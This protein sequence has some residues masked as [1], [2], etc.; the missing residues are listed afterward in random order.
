[1]RISRL[2]LNELLVRKNMTSKKLSECSGL[3]R[4]TISAINQGKRCRND[5]GI[6]LATALNVDV[7]ELLEVVE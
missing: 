1:M 4:Q 2:K 5:T 7:S 3:S 6:K